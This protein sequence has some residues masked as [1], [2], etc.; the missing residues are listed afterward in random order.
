MTTPHSKPWMW[1]YMY[2]LEIRK[3][4]DLAKD[5]GERQVT[6]RKFV[7][8]KL[9]AIYLTIIPWHR[10]KYC[11]ILHYSPRLKRMIV[12]VYTH[13]VISTKSERK[14]LKST[15]WSPDQITRKFKNRSSQNFQT[16]QFT[17]LSFRKQQRNG[18]NGTLKVWTVSLPEKKSGALLFSVDSPSL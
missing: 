1:M 4:Q 14:P 8:Q 2:I 3:S 16:W 11:T 13:E 17:S 6:P 9:W 12:L 10:G 5:I 7:N 15:I 18:L